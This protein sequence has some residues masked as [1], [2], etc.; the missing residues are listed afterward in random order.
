MIH[1]TTHRVAHPRRRN[2]GC[3][4]RRLCD[5]RVHTPLMCTERVSIHPTAGSELNIKI[6]N[7]EE[8]SFSRYSGNSSSD[9]KSIT[10]IYYIFF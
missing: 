3:T 1:H 6:K 7:E 4:V 8:G 5:S 2:P 10:I 9:Y